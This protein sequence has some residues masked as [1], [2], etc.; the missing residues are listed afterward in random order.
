[1]MKGKMYDRCQYIWMYYRGRIGIACLIAACVFYVAYSYLSQGRE[2]VL[3]AALVNE[4]VTQEALRPVEEGALGSMGYGKNKD[5]ILFMTGLSMDASNLDAN[6]ASGVLETLTAE[7]FAHEL[8]VIIGPREVIEYYAG[9][10]GLTDLGEMSGELHKETG[11]FALGKDGSTG[12]YALDLDG[13]YLDGYLDENQDNYISV[14][15]SGRKKEE[16]QKFLAY[17]F[18]K[19]RGWTGKDDTV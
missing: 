17:L 8:D 2:P 6:A 3:T 16:V 18:E 19:A 12:I 5:G 7:I 1:M 9:L 10:G 13:T 14:V 4:K 11:F 15:A